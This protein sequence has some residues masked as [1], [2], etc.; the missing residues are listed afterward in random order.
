MSIIGH[1]DF[2]QLY[3]S[4]VNEAKTE[5]FDQVSKKLPL[6]DIIKP[7]L[8]RETGLGV[9]LP[10]LGAELDG[11]ADTDESGTFSLAASNDLVGTALYTF[12]NGIITP[13]RIPWRTIEQTTGKNQLVDLVRAY[14]TSQSYAHGKDIVGQLYALSTTSGKTT[15]LFDVFSD[16]A[17][18]G[19][20]DPDDASYW[21]ASVIDSERGDE[22][23]GEALRRVFDAHE[24]ASNERPDIVWCAADVFA[25]YRAWLDSNKVYNDPRGRVGDFEFASLEYDG[26]EVRRDFQ[27]PEGSLFAACRDRLYVFSLN[28]NF[29]KVNPKGGPTPVYVHNEDGDFG[30][31][32]EVHTMVSVVQVGTT[33]RRC[34]SRLNRTDG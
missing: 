11:T 27:A 30:T 29:M 31:L 1:E 16:S 33:E 13:Y 15:S 9:Q 32:D 5:L 3:S 20:I 14:A 22:S 2:N 4:A 18:L 12:P 17:T 23:I 6:L 24:E 21:K 34:L 28:D 7:N 19:G 10:V 25:E 8:K 26:V